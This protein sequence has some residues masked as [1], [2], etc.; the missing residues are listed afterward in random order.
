MKKS[1]LIS[2]LIILYF[3]FFFPGQ[4]GLCPRTVQ[5]FGQSAESY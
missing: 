5:K 2:N 1:F 3:I 4:L